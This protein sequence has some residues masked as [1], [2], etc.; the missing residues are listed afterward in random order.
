MYCARITYCDVRTYT[1][2]CMYV[3][4]V[5]LSCTY[6]LHLGCDHLCCLCSTGWRS[7]PGHSEVHPSL[8]HVLHPLS[9]RSQPQ[10]HI[11]GT[12]L[13]AQMHHEFVQYMCMCIVCVCVY[14]YSV[15]MVLCVV[16]RGLLNACCVLSLTVCPLTVLPSLMCRLS[17]KVSWLS[18]LRR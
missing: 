16:D 7:E 17:P 15:C 2:I 12:V 8:Q 13:N 10:G 14:V 18:S 3:T 11:Q 1:Y 5:L 9:I 4:A 6:V